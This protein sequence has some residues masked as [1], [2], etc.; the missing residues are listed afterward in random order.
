MIYVHPF[1]SSMAQA[2]VLVLLA[3]TNADAQSGYIIVSKFT[4]RTLFLIHQNTFNMK[5][6]CAVIAE[7][8]YA[9]RSPSFP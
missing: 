7:N 3:M 8:M 2:A 5:Y 4:E 1:L 6:S 9:Y